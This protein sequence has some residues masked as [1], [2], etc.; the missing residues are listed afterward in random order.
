MVVDR[1]ELAS[2]LGSF[3]D[4]K[5]K[6]VLYVG[7]GGGQLLDP[8]WGPSKVVAIDS[9]AKALDVFR[10]EAKSK[11][12]GIQVEFVPK[13]FDQVN[14][15][16]EV[17]Y[18]E[19]CLHEMA[20]PAKALEHAHSMAKDIVVMDHLPG[21]EWIFYG[22][23]EAEVSRSTNAIEKFGTKLRESKIILQRFE[24]YQQLTA[25]LS[26][27]GPESLKRAARFKDTKEIIIK[28]DYGLFL[29]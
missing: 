23:E 27:V 12:S 28:M 26:E 20:E 19:F 24:D 14:E 5:G 10:N 11:W 15:K 9:N 18:F 17:V 29:L 25:R 8:S 13:P 3:Y 7:A 22:A 6:N 21:S 4:F 16:G 1:R 2:S